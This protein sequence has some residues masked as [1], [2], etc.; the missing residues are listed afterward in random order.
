MYILWVWR[1]TTSPPHHLSK[2]RVFTFY[3]LITLENT[4]FHTFLICFINNG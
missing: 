1:P 3:N 2:R 4:R